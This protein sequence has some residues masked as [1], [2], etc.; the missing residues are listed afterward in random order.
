MATY[1]VS[2]KTTADP[3]VMTLRVTYGTAITE[4]YYVPASIDTDNML[5]QNLVKL[6]RLGAGIVPIKA[7]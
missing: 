5:I 7:K 3:D 4:D 6:S 1:I 2:T